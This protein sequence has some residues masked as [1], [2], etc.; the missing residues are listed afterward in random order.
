MCVTKNYTARTPGV[1]IVLAFHRNIQSTRF[2]HLIVV[3]IIHSSSTPHPRAKTIEPGTTWCTE[4]KATKRIKRQHIA[5]EKTQEQQDAQYQA[6]EP[7]LEKDGNMISPRRLSST[8]RRTLDNHSSNT[9]QRIQ[10][11][12]S[13][14]GAKIEYD[15]SQGEA[16]H[17]DTE[18]V[19]LRGYI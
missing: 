18:A 3:L 9:I 14:L 5:R 8:A 12:T 11:L 17:K 4:G 1:H 13:I 2:T 19:L 6:D 15:D 10:H 16:R 7:I